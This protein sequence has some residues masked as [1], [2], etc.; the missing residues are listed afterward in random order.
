MLLSMM[1]ITSIVIIIQIHTESNIMAV[2]FGTSLLDRH[3]F[4]AFSY[5]F[6]QHFL[7]LWQVLLVGTQHSSSA[8][9]L[10][11]RPL[12]P[13]HHEISTFVF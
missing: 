7:V 13:A 3:F 6:S 11:G 9:A 10:E 5:D 2:G 4:T 1:I 8:C 12:P